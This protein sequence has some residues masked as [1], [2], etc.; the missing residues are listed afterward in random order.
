MFF[1]IHAFLGPGFS[2]SRFFR[3]QVF[4][5]PGFSGPRF[6]SVRV[7]VLEVASKKIYNFSSSN[8][9]IIC[10]FLS[11]KMIEWLRVLN[12][13]ISLRFLGVKLSKESK[14]PFRSLWIQKQPSRCVIIKR[15]SKNM[16]KVCRRISMLKCDFNKV[17][18]TALRHGCSPLNLLRIF[19]TRFPKNTWTAASVSWEILKSG[20]K[21]V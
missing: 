7:Q 4:Q 6:F 20:R 8:L 12:K 11:N 16:Q 5:D 3:V 10:V 21:Y 18:E 9:K 14:R 1:R 17:A 13:L 2:E 19:R 15:C